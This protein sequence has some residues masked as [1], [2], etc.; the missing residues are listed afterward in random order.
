MGDAAGPSSGGCVKSVLPPD[1]EE[2]RLAIARIHNRLTI[3]LLFGFMG[4]LL[5]LARFVPRP[6][7]TGGMVTVGLA[8]IGVEIYAIY[9]I[10][11]YDKTLCV[12]L[13][14]VCPHC[15]KPLYEP[16]GI[17]NVTGRCPKCRKSV[18]A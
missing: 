6:W 4:S 8:L 11:E 18:A 10:F 7:N 16:R 14:F 15:G 17:I 2:K 9:R 5:A 3:I 13:R 12:R 1:L